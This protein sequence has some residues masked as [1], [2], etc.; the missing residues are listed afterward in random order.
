MP[1]LR[2]RDALP[3]P[4][5]RYLLSKVESIQWPIRSLVAPLP[6]G[7]RTKR[8]AR[9]S[10]SLRSFCEKPS[11]INASDFRCMRS[12]P[13]RD[14]FRRLDPGGP[15]V[16]KERCLELRGWFAGWRLDGDCRL[17]QLTTAPNLAESTVPFSRL[18]GTLSISH[19]IFH[20]MKS[21]T[22]RRP[23]STENGTVPPR[24][25]PN[26]KRRP[27]E[28]LTVKEVGLLMGTSRERGR[29]GHRDATMIL[30]AYRHGLR[31]A[32]LC[33]LRWDQVD[34]GRG[35]LHVRRRMNCPIFAAQERDAKRAPET[36]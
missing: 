3:E 17:A 13:T 18:N 31:A 30:T 5:S 16:Q 22:R 4:Q 11:R 27:R 6:L 25:V 36:R 28:Y 19:T 2:S 12:Q 20:R 8:T 7:R 1:H 14:G 9:G 32:E 34:F 10:G 29:Y 15:R 23:P 35:L 26:S 21:T 33:T 24:R